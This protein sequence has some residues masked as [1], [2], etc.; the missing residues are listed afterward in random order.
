MAAQR[1]I[2]SLSELMDGGVEER[3]NVEMN[4]I[5]ANVQD[6]NT[7]PKAKREIQIKITVK[8][9]ERRDSADFDVQVIGKPAPFKPLSKTVTLQFNTDGS[10]VATERTEQIPGQMNMDGGE[11]PLARVVRFDGTSDN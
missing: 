1:P 9:N 6:P 5:W 7:D 10:V 4:K 2:K 8:P 11:Q 3:F